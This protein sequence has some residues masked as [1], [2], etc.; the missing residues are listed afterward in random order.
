[1]VAGRPFWIL[2]W[3]GILALGLLGLWAS[4]YWGRRTHWRN[5]D[6]LLRAVGTIQASVGMLLLLFGLASWSGTSL[7]ALALATFVTAFLAGREL[8][9]SDEGATPD[10]VT[11]PTAE[12]RP[13]EHS[14]VVRD[15]FV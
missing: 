2:V 15:S 13:A 4:V 3:F 11:A 7:L 9:E 10:A 6:E 1:M 12:S 14:V 5:V 8:Q